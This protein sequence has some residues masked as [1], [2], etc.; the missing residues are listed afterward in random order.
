MPEWVWAGLA[1]LLAGGALLAGSVVGWFARVPRRIVAAVMAFGSG[2]LISA[3]AFDPTVQVE[4][5]GVEKAITIDPAGSVLVVLMDGDARLRHHAYAELLD[6]QTDRA[7]SW[8]DHDEG[9]VVFAS[10]PGRLLLRLPKLE[11]FAPIADREVVIQPGIQ[12]R[13]TIQLVRSP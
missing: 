13:V 6:G 2:V 11:S 8:S 7:I 10:Q 5:G 1:G 3:L 4:A 9:C 12:T